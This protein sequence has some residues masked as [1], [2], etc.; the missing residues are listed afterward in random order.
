[1][2]NLSPIA[3]FC[4]RRLDT[5]KIC[6][7]SLKLCPEAIHSELFIFSDAAKNEA[8][9]LEVNQLRSYLN[10]IDGFK[11]IK[12]NLR[13]DNLG[14]DFNIINGIKEM[15]V[16]Y[17]SF[18]VVEDD[19]I[20]SR[21]FLKFMNAGLFFYKSF[22]SVLTLSAFNYVKIPENYIWDIYFAKRTNPWGWATWSNK[23]K[24]VDWDLAIKENFLNNPIEMRAFNEWGSD[25]SRML[26]RTIFSDIRAWDIRLDYYQFKKDYLTAYSCKNLVINNGFNDKRAS[27][28]SGYNRFKIL[29][30]KYINIY[31]N[32][33]D[34]IFINKHIKY[35]YVSKNSF[36][37][38]LFTQIFKKLNIYNKY[39]Q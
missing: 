9:L 30:E 32:L 3:L 16:N 5:L 22:E 38:R 23:I 6:V 19:L 21:D 24:E 12:I 35:K 2:F 1:M 4:F 13:K 14:V 33:P 39:D 27:N 10:E 20:V 17:E 29:H 15:S 28:T 31:F 26:K 18:I 8:E 34:F 7:E 37:Q 36:L 11:S 25:R